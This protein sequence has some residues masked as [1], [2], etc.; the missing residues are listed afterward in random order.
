MHIPVECKQRETN[1]SIPKPSGLMKLT[2]IY[3]TNMHFTKIR[4]LEIAILSELTF[5]ICVIVLLISFKCVLA[6]L[7]IK[8]LLKLNGS[9]ENAR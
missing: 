1:N 9:K 2:N 3:F 7:H 6:T 5:C 8:Q 4:L